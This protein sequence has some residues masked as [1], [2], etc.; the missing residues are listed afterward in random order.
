MTPIWLT[1]QAVSDGKTHTSI[2]IT[3]NTANEAQLC[4]NDLFIKN[5]KIK[6]NMFNFIKPSHQRKKCMKF[7]HAKINYKNVITCNFYS[8]THDTNNH[9]CN[10]YNVIR[11]I[12]IY[13]NFKCVN[14]N[15]NHCANDKNCKI[16]TFMQF[17]KFI[18]DN[19]MNKL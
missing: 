14:C 13:I 11:K 4:K 9:K 16:I 5:I 19:M 15:E 1:K 8:L 3:L 17:K 6:T 10:K 12:C 2:V 18:V 7:K